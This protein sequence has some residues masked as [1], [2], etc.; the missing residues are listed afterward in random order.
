MRSHFLPLLAASLC[1]ACSSTPAPD[2][3]TGGTA[4]GGS[5]TGGTGGGTSGGTGAPSD[6]GTALESV[7]LQQT[8]TASSLTAPVDVVRDTWGNP[9]I[10]GSN[11]SDIA[12]VQGYMM[13]HDR[14]IEMDLARHEADGSLASIIGAASPSALAQDIGMRA[15]HLRTQAEANWAALQA[16]SDPTDK[17]LVG[18]LTAYAAGVNA[19]WSDLSAGMYTLPVD[20]AVVYQASSFIQWQPE[21][22]LLLG[23]LFAYELGFDASDEIEATQVATASDLTFD[24]G[25]PRAGFGDDIQTVAPVD[26]TTTIA[27]W[28]PLIGDT[29]S[30]SREPHGVHRKAGQGPNLQLLDQDRRALASLEH[31]EAGHGHGSNNWVVGPSLSATGHAMVANDTHLNL[32][33]PATFWISHMV[34]RGADVALNVMGE[35]FPGVPAVTLGVNQHAAWGA[36]VSFIDVTDV[37]QETITP[38]PEDAGPCSFFDGGPNPLVED[39]E[40][41]QIGYLGTI[42]S[43]VTLDLWQVP[44]HGPIIPRVQFDAQGNVTGVAAPGSLP[45]GQELSVK[46]T[47]FTPYGTH[48]LFKAIWGLDTAGSMQQAVAALDANFKYGGQ[49]WVIVDDQG[50]FG[51]TQTERVPRRAPPNLSANPPELNLPWHIL[52]GDGTA[53]WGPDMDPHWIPHAFNPAKGFL[54]TANADPIGATQANDPFLGQPVEDGGPL[55]LGAF[56]DPGTRVGRITKRIEGFEDAGHKISLDDMQSIQADAVTEWEQGMAPT[57]LEAS[58]ALLAEAAALD[59]GVAAGDAGVGPYPELAPL[60]TAAAGAHGGFTIP[61]LQQ[62]QTLVQNW[63][64]DTPAGVAIFDGGAPTAQQLSDSQATLVAAYWT[65]HFLHDTLDDEIAAVAAHNPGGESFSNE[66]EESKLMFFLCQNP[67][68]AFLKTGSEANGDSI[69]FDNLNTPA[70][71]TKLMVAAQ[72]LIE[73]LDGVV[74]AQG[75]DPSQWAWGRAHTLT[76]N[77]LGG[78]SAAPSL[79]LPAPGDTAFPNGYPR[80]GENGT[81]DVG[82]HGIDTTSYVYEDLGPAIRFTAELDPTNGPIA[83]NALPG[84]EI[85]D[86]SSPHYDDQLQLWLQ[87]KTFDFA[88]QD[89]DVI[90]QANQECAKNQICRWRFQ[91]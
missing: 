31:L 36:T 14:L 86:P 23:E 35:Q 9:H 47:G 90:S 29:T 50:N 91:P 20:Y 5:S 70:V 80:H 89:A 3:G 17:L 73:G 26:P 71:E 16:S 1:L 63:T 24:G 83:R 57:F 49:N 46:Y 41:F 39:P 61:L 88:Y 72:A 74:A 21:D 85:F 11:L 38:C 68:P 58:N 18:A 33:N 40:T 69:L 2:A 45:G 42:D 54:A 82:Q 81:V 67:R 6:G 76:L 30:A 79:S 87:N 75:S 8:F 65:T 51:W 34:D 48:M 64:F 25:D 56:Y 78:Q 32:D 37:Y 22:S 66:Y 7:T 4:G 53:E 84:G 19:Y 52:P 10:Y 12:Y 60:L 44:Q 43:S 28:P 77:F 55:Y 62:A 15:Y 27:G 13:A 59:G